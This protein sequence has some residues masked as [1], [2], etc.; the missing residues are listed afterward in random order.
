MSRSSS[1]NQTSLER[2]FQKVE[3]ELLQLKAKQQ[4]NPDQ[5][6]YAYTSNTVS[7]ASYQYMSGQSGQGIIASLLFTSYFPNIYPKTSMTFAR[8]AGDTAGVL[9]D[10]RTERAGSNQARLYIQAVDTM[11]P[12]STPKAFT[13]NFT[14]LSNVAGALTLEKT[15]VIP[16]YN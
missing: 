7:I 10:C 16:G 12:M 6:N 11:I 14:V 13:G 15:Y 3:T 5:I 2:Q 1:F 9:I 8:S 4:Y